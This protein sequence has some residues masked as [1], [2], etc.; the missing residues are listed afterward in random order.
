[1]FGIYAQHVKNIDVRKENKMYAFV[2]RFIKAAVL[3][4]IFI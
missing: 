4:N 3:Q 1:M 2:L